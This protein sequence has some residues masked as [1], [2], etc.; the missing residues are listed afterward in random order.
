MTKDVENNQTGQE[1][2]LRHFLE[3]HYMQQTFDESHRLFLELNENHKPFDKVSLLI[4]TNQSQF[5]STQSKVDEGL[6]QSKETN[7][8]RRV[9]KIALHN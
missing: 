5:H 1:V 3:C 2:N 7:L 6:L 4:L 8:I 9:N